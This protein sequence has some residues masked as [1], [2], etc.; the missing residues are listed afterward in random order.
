MTYEV[1]RPSFNIS[2]KTAAIM[3]AFLGTITSPWWFPEL[4]DTLT[5]NQEQVEVSTMSATGDGG[6]V[7][8]DEGIWQEAIDKLE[9]P[10]EWHREEI[11][12]DV[13]A[14]WGN[15]GT[16]DIEGL[17]ELMEDLFSDG[18]VE[19]LD[20][21]V[22]DLDFLEEQ[23]RGAIEY[24]ESEN[25]LE[26]DDTYDRL[27]EKL[28]TIESWKPV[29]E[30]LN[31][32]DA[33]E[34]ERK[35]A[36]LEMDGALSE[37]TVEVLEGLQA[38]GE[39]INNGTAPAMAKDVDRLIKTLLDEHSTNEQIREAYDVVFDGTGITIEKLSQEL[40]NLENFRTSR[41][42]DDLEE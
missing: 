21:I 30:L 18:A 16:P 29:V 37:T 25:G 22:A 15:T 32:E 2:G 3:A 42:P 35:V 20:E 9:I 5:E 11:P 8:I 4:A 6:E 12:D 34:I 23:I 33:A 36:E 7:E 41:R 10:D 24:L 1:S 19:A 17:D 26:L 40:A 39:S 14:G 38:L 27:E 28:A 13:Y 31:G